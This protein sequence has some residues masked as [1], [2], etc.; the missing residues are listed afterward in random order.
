M[1]RPFK[2]LDRVE[3]TEE[4]GGWPAGTIGTIVDL[5]PGGAVVERPDC[6]TG[7]L[8]DDLMSVPFEALRL[9]EQ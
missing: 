3:L 2:E 9:V 4:V 7:S 6:G 5:E 8:L 1:N